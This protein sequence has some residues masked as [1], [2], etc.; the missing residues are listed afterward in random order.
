MMGF[1]QITIQNAMQ[2]EFETVLSDWTLMLP[3][4]N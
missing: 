3:S 1:F 2:V 4:L